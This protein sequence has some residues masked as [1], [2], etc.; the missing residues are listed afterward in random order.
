MRRSRVAVQKV[1]A[2]C[3]RC[4]LLCY[5]FIMAKESHSKS[6]AKS[7]W[8]QEYTNASHLAMST[9]PSSDLESFM[10]WSDRQKDELERV[11]DRPRV[12]DIGCGNGRNVHY[13]EKVSDAMGGGIDVAEHAIA[14]AQKHARLPSNFMV[15][16]I[17]D[18]PYVVGDESQDLI[19][20][21]MSSHIL[22]TKQRV[23]LRQ[24]IDRILVPGGFIFFKTFLL[25][26]DINA[27]EMIR[28]QPGHEPNS[29]VHHRIGH[30]EYMLNLDQ[31]I[32]EIESQG[33]IIH[34]ISKSH[35]HIKKGQAGKR[36]TVSFYIQ[37]PYDW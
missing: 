2:G 36:R 15:H 8:E 20:D 10:R 21:M 7:F 11:V 24:E 22:D 4:F 30:T 6:R 35:K 28:K 14:Q 1:Y 26:G 3:N 25:D 29:Y 5:N 33:W 13:M 23:L 34:K 18:F 37:K 16:R 32:S 27:K 9:E 31:I 17:E 12:F 19:L